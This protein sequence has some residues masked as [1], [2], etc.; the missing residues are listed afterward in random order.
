MIRLVSILFALSAAAVADEQ[1]LIELQARQQVLRAALTEVLPSVVRIDTIG[2]MAPRR[3]GQ[4]PTFRQADGPT[5][6]LIVAADGWILTSSFNFVRDPTVITVRLHDGRRLVAKLVARDQIG[7]LALLKVDAS[8]LPTPTFVSLDTVQ[9]GQLAFAAGYG[10]G[11]STPSMS[12]GIVSALG[13]IDG[14]ALQSDARVSPA[15]Y[16]GPLCDRDGRVL[17]ICVP[18]TPSG[19]ELAGA[20]WYDSGIAFAVRPDFFQPRLKR[21][22]QGD[23]LQRGLLG[24]F[25]DMAMPVVGVEDEDLSVPGRRLTRAP[26]GPA[27]AAGMQEGDIITAVNETPVPT[28]VDLRRILARHVAGDVLSVTYWRDGETATVD[29]T[30]W[31]TDQLLEEAQREAAEAQENGAGNG[32][33]GTGEESGGGDDE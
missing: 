24:V 27:K 10:H 30:L 13:R 9:P 1:T 15:S 12:V 28:P 3:D 32:E 21:L 6:G 23:D 11:S 20:E 18:L 31:S 4:R 7:K 16:G 19:D 25:L 26:S 8:D 22:Q 5:T 17:G 2:G 29:L 33:P 14:I